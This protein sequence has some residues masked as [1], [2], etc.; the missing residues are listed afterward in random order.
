VVA[1]PDIEEVS[2][3]FQSATILIDLYRAQEAERRRGQR[4]ADHVA[5]F[6]EGQRAASDE[7]SGVS[8]GDRA[9]GRSHEA[10]DLGW[11]DD[12]HPAPGG[13]QGA[14]RI[15]GPIQAQPKS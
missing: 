1:F 13:E 2:A 5:A 9:G 14:R 15:V 3:M 10:A 6:R 7:V 4:N 11:G 12:L 8:F